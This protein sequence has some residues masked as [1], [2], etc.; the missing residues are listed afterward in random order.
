MAAATA[1]KIKKI[2][3][4]IEDDEQA[5][6]LWIEP[7]LLPTRL[8]QRGL[9]G[10]PVQTIFE[11]QLKSPEGAGKNRDRNGSQEDRRFGS[12]RRQRPE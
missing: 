11:S 1:K 6:G 2:Q 12:G 10:Q 3:H 9:R 5:T 8:A 4:L 7:S